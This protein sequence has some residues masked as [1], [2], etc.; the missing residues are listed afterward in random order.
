LSAEPTLFSPS[1]A[2]CS[3]IV[4]RTS[5]SIGQLLD[6]EPTNLSHTFK[7]LITMQQPAMHK[8]LDSYQ[9]PQQKLLCDNR[10]FSSELLHRLL[11]IVYAVNPPFTGYL[12]I[13][14]DDRSLLFLFFFNGVPYAAGRYADS[15]PVCYSIQELGSHLARSAEES[16]SVT[17]CETDP[18]LLKS[19]L[20]F[21][22]EEPVIKA[23]PSLLD[24]EYI[25]RQIG[26]VGAN[27]MIALCRDKKINFFFFRDG[28]G[29]L[30]HYADLAFER[31]EGMT[32]EEEMLLYAF[33]PGDKV[34]AYVFRDMITTMS[35]DSNQLDKDSL[36]KLLTAGYLRNRRSSDT[37]ISPMP[38]ENP[39]NRRKGDTEISPIPAM[40]GIEALV[41]ALHHKPKLTSVVLSVESGPQQG[42]RITV[43]LPCT[44]GRKDCDLILDDRLI[45][46][47]HAE[48]KI[49]EDELVIEDLASTNG[50]KVNGKTVTNTRLIPN[51]LI[52]IGP[53]SLR[54]SPA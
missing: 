45:S 17:L 28:K 14:G 23:P 25:V 12:E 53:T 41:K 48:L 2:A 34:Q 43:M 20:L 21:L 10:P 4:E 1:D 13:A 11:D 51:D 38:D 32:F 44:I 15:K 22:Q 35:E 46:R 3:A 47:R 36:Y 33:Q 54:I 52:S 24:F 37:V 18:V 49:V 7:E 39:E 50:T 29:A 9:F 19:M 16:M 30:A 42:E 31:P 6:W 5:G 26:E 8:N 40:G 27:A